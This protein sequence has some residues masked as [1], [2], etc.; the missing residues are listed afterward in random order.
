MAKARSPEFTADMSLESCMPD[1]DADVNDDAFDV[2]TFEAY[3]VCHA[4]HCF[5]ASSNP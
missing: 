3:S 1:A 2:A 4:L 5:A